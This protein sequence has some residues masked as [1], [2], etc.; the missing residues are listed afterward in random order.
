MNKGQQAMPFLLDLE[1]VYLKEKWPQLLT[2]VRLLLLQCFQMVGDNKREFKVRCQLSASTLLSDSERLTHYNEAERLLMSIKDST[3]ESIVIRME[4]IFSIDDISL[5]FK[6]NYTVTNCDIELNLK[7]FN[8]F[9]KAV[10][11]EQLLVTLK[12]EQNAT[13]TN[14]SKPK[15]SN[16]ACPHL[17]ALLSDQNKDKPNEDTI[18]IN[19]KPYIETFHS[20]VSV[21]VKCNNS[22]KALR[23]S[24]SHGFFLLDKDPEIDNSMKAFVVNNITVQPGLNNIKLNYNSKEGGTFI[25]NQIILKLNSIAN[26]VETNLKKHICFNV[27]AEEPSLKVLQLTTLDGITSDILS[28]VEQSIVLQLNC[29]SFSFEEQLPITIRAS[30][31][32]QLKLETDLTSPLKDDISFKLSNALN[33]FQTFTIPLIIKSKLI[34]QK[35]ANAIQH[36]LTM[37]WTPNGTEKS[38]WISVTFHLLPPFISS[39]KLHTCNLRKFVEV[40]VHGVSKRNIVLAK[41][42]LKLSDHFDHEQIHLEGR[43]PEND[44]IIHNN[45]TVHYL[46]EIIASDPKMTANKVEFNL[47]YKLVEDNIDENNGWENFECDYKLSNYQTLYTIKQMVEPQKGTEFCRVGNLCHLNVTITRVNAADD[48]NSVMY[49]VIS[50]QSLWNL[51]G[52][53]AG[54]VTI[55]QTDKHDVTFEVMPLISGFLP[56]PTVRLSKYIS[57]NTSNTSDQSE[58]KL[59]AFEIGQ[60]Y[61][62]S[63]ATQVHVLPSSGL[64]V[65]EV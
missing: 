42:L 30:H 7:I 13:S 34:A 36:E 6:D 2:H 61:N 35:D 33:P 14:L 29:G 54:V 18:K 48:H 28:G 60:V 58:A 62:W 64:I 63:R 21:G 4:D 22:T 65:P 24:E 38:K 20:S 59:I 9:P 26:I 32:L 41:P 40:L 56:L 50:D 17:T 51:S 45:Q 49:E 52:R 19:P 55:D 57:S 15:K 11:F 3:N 47:K 37:S 5:E 8:N 46:W 43:L 44:S 1:K 53:T 39:Y 16:K 25:L 12:V 23:R 27:I 10:E 31:A